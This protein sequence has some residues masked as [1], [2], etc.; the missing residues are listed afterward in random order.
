MIAVG[1]MSGSGKTT[2]GHALGHITPG[3]IFLD[4]DVLKKKMFGVDPLTTLPDAVYA[5]DQIQKF[6][7]FIREE[8]AKEMKNHDVVIV[9]GLFIDDISRIEQRAFAEKSDAD[10]I[11]IYLHAPLSVIF[12]RFQKRDD[13]PSDATLEVIK[14][15][16]RMLLG[17][18]KKYENWAV[19]DSD[20]S[21]EN[22]LNDSLKA[23]NKTKSQ[24]KYPKQK[25]C[26]QKKF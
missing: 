5:P 3:A 16:A 13:T 21:F 9:T 12:S 4:S 23:I 19:V 17:K 2:I 6:I 14:R 26:L 20:Q 18:N 15:Q 22:V 7:K 24:I 25:K 10:F 1:G 11:G 8:V